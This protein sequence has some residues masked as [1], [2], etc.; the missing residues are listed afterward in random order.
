MKR[1]ILFRGKRVDRD[2]WVEGHYWYYD[3]QDGNKDYFIKWYD[4]DYDQYHDAR[5]HPET[6]GQYTG[7]TDKNGNKIYEGDITE[8]PAG[9]IATVDYSENHY[10]GFICN[11]VS[12]D[13]HWNL[14][15]LTVEVIGNIFE[16][17]E[18]LKK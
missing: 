17:P 11:E 16:N 2:E 9:Q 14:N 15:I 7:L 18:V 5:V 8:T 6:V 4:K 3:Y 12:T 10:Q 13:W 1:E